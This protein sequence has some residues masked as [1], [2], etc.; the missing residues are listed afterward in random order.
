MRVLLTI[1]HPAHVHFFKH[2]YRELRDRGHE[3]RVCLREKSVAG[4]LLEAYGLE[5]T[6]LADASDSIGAMVRTQLTYEWRLLEVAREFDPDVVAAIGG[7]AAS[8]VARLVGARGVVF[9][10]TEHARLSN[11]LT[12][13]FADAVY[14]P[15]CYREA[16]GA[17]QRRY[18]GYHELAYL[19]PDR[20]D[21]DPSVF[22]GL[23]ASPDDPYVVL[24]LIAWN[25]SHD[26]GH[27]GFDDAVDA[28]DRLEAT[29]HR[30]LVTAEGEMPAALRDRR[31][32]IEPHRMHDLLAYADLFVGE[33][34]T[35]AAESAVLG[36]PAI[37]VN[38]LSMGYIDELNRRYGLLY[39]YH[40]MDR[41]RDALEAAVAVLET[42]V[43][44]AARRERMLA[45]KTDTTDV[46][47][48]AVLDR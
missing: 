7:L 25:A 39:G 44:W 6:S 14:T 34:A 24:R 46:V 19:H 21:P 4:D 16:V 40:D 13:P 48:D 8:H 29:G 38:S 45:E 1:Q 35:T 32:E 41:H 31:V 20:F 36:T 43:D 47:L 33:G 11:G 2:A 5:Y 27:G 18:P 17:K 23:D 10:D 30:V 15:E 28:V 26:V 12:F 9:T 3:V 22:D 42:D 37:Y